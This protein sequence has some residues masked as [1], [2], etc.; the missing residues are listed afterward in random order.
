MRKIVFVA[1]VVLF[2]LHQDFWNWSNRDLWFGFLPAGLG[3][4]AIYS[5]LA[6][7]LWAVAAFCAWPSEIEAF[8]E[9]GETPAER[10][11]LDQ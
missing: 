8:G 3:Y 6:S 4:H 11:P 1:A 2:F 5:I 7:L 10:G 9:I